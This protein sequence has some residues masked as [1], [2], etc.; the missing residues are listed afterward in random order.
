MR[1]AP[2]RRQA[3]DRH[4]CAQTIS[5]N[6]VLRQQDFAQMTAA[7]LAEAKRAIAQLTLPFDEV[8]TRRYKPAAASC[9]SIRA[10]PCGRRCAPAAT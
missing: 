8:E 10:R 9:A 1:S 5:G 6:E 4:R 3:D 7:E 2:A